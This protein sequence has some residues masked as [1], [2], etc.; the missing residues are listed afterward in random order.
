MDRQRTEYFVN[1][2]R[3]LDLFESKQTT[4]TPRF[5]DGTEGAPQLIAEYFAVSE[6]RLKALPADKLAEM[7]K[8]GVLGQI[9]AHLVS[10]AGF[11]RLIAET[12][13]RQAA[14]TPA[15]ANA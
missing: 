14:A 7:A 3:E 1:E 6:D 8:S 15:A 12:S 2:L 9:Y 5:A 11:D 13:Q 10:L 4:F